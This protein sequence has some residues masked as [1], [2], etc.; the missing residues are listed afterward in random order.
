MKRRALLGTL[1]TL[2]VAGCTGTDPGSGGTDTTEATTAAPTTADP[3]TTQSGTPPAIRDLGVPADQADCPFESD[4]V[5]R[6]VCHPQQTDEP[7]VV[8]PS[9]DTVDLPNGSVTFT[10][11]NDTTATYS[12]NFY[13]WGLHKRVDGQWFH[14]TPRLVPESLHQVP[15]GESH[16]WAVQIDNTM[17]PTVGPSDKSGGTL[18]GL[19]GGEY[20][21]EVSGW[22]EFDDHSHTVGLGAHI[23]LEGDQVELTPS[24]DLA[25]DR[26]DDTVVATSTDEDAEPTEAFVVKRVG[27]G[28]VPPGKPINDHIAE[29]LVRPSLDEDRL[30]L[31]DALA[32]FADGVTT[33]RVR[34]AE[35]IDPRRFDRDQRYYLQFRGGIYEAEVVSLS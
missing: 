26:D 20:A 21:F 12:V 10:L 4:G 23:D 6:V 17:D 7:L 32:L 19:G 24:D 34:S 27:E 1:A 13:D 9:T 22:F 8:T 35:E 30:W 2:T 3:T 5:E 33:V 28:G 14:V 11:T 31:R 16:E 29:Q 25:A 18:A 15:P